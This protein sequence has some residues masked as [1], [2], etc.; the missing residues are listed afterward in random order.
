VLESSALLRTLT[1]EQLEHLAGA[2]HLFTCDK[3]EPIWIH[4]GNVKF[5]GL[6]ANGFV[7]MVRSNHSGL[8]MTMEIMGPGQIF[9][10]LGTMYESGCPLMAYGMTDTTY[11]RIPKAAFLEVYDANHHLKDHLVRRTARRMHEKLD[12]MGKLWNGRAEERL[13]AIL[14]ILSDSYSEPD[15]EWLRLN[16]PLTRQALAEM[17]ATTTETTIRVFSAWTNAGIL[18][19]DQQVIRFKADKLQLKL[20]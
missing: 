3:N 12:F 1:P 6:V 10:L 15:G 8:E 5:F 19:T 2:C 9:G 17:A 18:Q 20:D 11:V 13:A 14:M 7:K 4:G 16:V